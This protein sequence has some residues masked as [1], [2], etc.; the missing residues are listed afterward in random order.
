MP[1]LA[2]KSRTRATNRRST[3]SAVMSASVVMLLTFSSCASAPA[4]S[5]FR[6]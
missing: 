5:I 2:L 6:A 1:T 3:S 4:S